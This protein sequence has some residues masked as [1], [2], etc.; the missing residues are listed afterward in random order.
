[1]YILSVILCLMGCW[2]YVENTNTW[3]HMKCR[4]EHDRFRRAPTI[5]RDR[6][7][8][9]AV[10]SPTLDFE[11]SMTGSQTVKSP[12][13]RRRKRMTFHIAEPLPTTTR[14]SPHDS[15]NNRAFCP[16]D[17]VTDTDLRRIPRRMTKAVCQNSTGNECTFPSIDLADHNMYHQLRLNSHCEPIYSKI[18]VQYECC[19]RGYYRLR[20]E[21]ID[22]QS[23][24]ICAR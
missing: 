6:Y 19:E 12:T 21:W 18:Q 3:M 2:I 17:L 22:W 14:A 20:T 23:A 4:W 9:Q 8:M 13:K 1:M 7:L 5:K 15:L 11:S 10:Y 24:C 16:W